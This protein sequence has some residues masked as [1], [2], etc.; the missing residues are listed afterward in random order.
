MAGMCHGSH[1]RERTLPQNLDG[2]GD[3]E[4]VELL[5]AIMEMLLHN[6]LK[7]WSKGLSEHD[8]E[9][10]PEYQRGVRSLDLELDAR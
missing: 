4:I 10:M 8:L 1:K 9:D 3:M 7:S 5:I 6:I 2:S